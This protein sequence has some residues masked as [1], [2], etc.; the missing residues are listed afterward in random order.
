M[1]DVKWLQKISA[2]GVVMLYR[3]NKTDSYSRDL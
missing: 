2:V 1:K 3:K